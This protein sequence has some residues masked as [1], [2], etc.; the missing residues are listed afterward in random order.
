M[1]LTGKLKKLNKAKV[2]KQQVN[3]FIKAHK[4]EIDKFGKIHTDLAN[5]CGEEFGNKK[6]QRIFSALMVSSI[7]GSIEGMSKSDKLKIIKELK[8][9]V[10][11]Q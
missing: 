1:K 7:L 10:E 2:M 6:H 3:E 11:K 5:K 8:Q 4:K 9:L